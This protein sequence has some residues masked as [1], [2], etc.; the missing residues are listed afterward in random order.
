MSGE[1]F[2]AT[3]SLIFMILIARATNTVSRLL[4]ISHFCADTPI[5]RA[6]RRLKIYSELAD[7]KH[8]EY[9]GY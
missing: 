3:L 1:T 4:I 2:T 6:N 5:L 9:S 8:F 7:V